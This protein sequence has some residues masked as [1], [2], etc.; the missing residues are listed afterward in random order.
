M[1]M[2][3]KLA[4]LMVAGVLIAGCSESRPSGQTSRV[5]PEAALAQES[6]GTFALED[7]V[8]GEPIRHENLSIFP[9]ISRAAKT[10][11]RYITLDE[12]LQAGTIEIREVAATYQSIAGPTGSA[13]ASATS[14][15]N[16][17]ENP[18]A[19]EQLARDSRQAD[20][21]LSAENDVNTLVVVNNSDKPLYLMPGEI[22]IGG[23]QD[24][25]IANELVIAA[26]SS[27]TRIP[28]YCV[29][30]G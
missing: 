2:S 13:D 11:D 17:K 9:V 22:I 24:R 16:D 28:V 19:D 5:K 21:E 8:V 10:E 18:P 1:V 15:E 4:G 6:A 14:L 20:G 27:P 29:E 23:S 25:T 30:S 26:H 12:G 7:F 3:R